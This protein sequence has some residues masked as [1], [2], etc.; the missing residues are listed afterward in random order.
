TLLDLVGFVDGVERGVRHAA[1]GLP[2]DRT[3]RRQERAALQALDLRFHRPRPSRAAVTAGTGHARLRPENPREPTRQVFTIR[4]RSLLRRATHRLA[5]W[6]LGR[7]PGPQ[8]RANRVA[9]LAPR[10][11][12]RARSHRGLG[13]PP[14]PV[15]SRWNR[16]A[17][18]I[19]SSG[20]L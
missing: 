2:S 9:P 18:T 12:G 6:F 14:L 20:R 17:D 13:G 10:R 19:L 15:A 5:P 1:S 8:C 7:L 16:G 3:G 4:L 11:P